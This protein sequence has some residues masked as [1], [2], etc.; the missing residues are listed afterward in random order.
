MHLPTFQGE[1]AIAQGVHDVVERGL[2]RHVEE[3]LVVGVAGDVFD[4]GDERL[5]VLLPSDVVT[6]DLEGSVGEKRRE[7]LSERAA[8]GRGC[9]WRVGGRRNMP[10]LWQLLFQQRKTKLK[11][12]PFAD[13]SGASSVFLEQQP[14]TVKNR[15]ITALLSHHSDGWESDNFAQVTSLLRILNKYI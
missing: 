6:E 11:Q 10:C 12:G 8:G 4:L 14:A 15:H 9:N 3:V 5:G 1:D 2:V 13:E 7:S